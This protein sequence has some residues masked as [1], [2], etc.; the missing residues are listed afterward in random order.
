MPFRTKPTLLDLLR[1][2]NNSKFRAITNRAI[3]AGYTPLP[4]S[5]S[6]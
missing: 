4:V 5:K 2:K 6:S 3:S 1:P